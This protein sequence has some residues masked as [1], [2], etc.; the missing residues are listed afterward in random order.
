[1]ALTLHITQIR[2]DTPP[3]TTT[4]PIPTT[5]DHSSF[6]LPIPKPLK[7]LYQLGDANTQSA[8]EKASDYLYELT[9][10]DD[11][12]KTHID[13]AAK[14]AISMLNTDH[15]HAQMIW[16]MAQQTPLME[17]KKLRPPKA[18]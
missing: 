12:T 7:D 5:R 17:L 3:T 9:S 2:D 18:K 16:P 14:H 11:T 1:M 6:I 8:L 10:S 15:Q 4:P 13:K